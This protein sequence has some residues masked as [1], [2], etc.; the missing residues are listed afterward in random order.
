MPDH[1][2]VRRKTVWTILRWTRFQGATKAPHAF[3]AV[4]AMDYMGADCF[5]ERAP[6]V[7]PTRT[8]LSQL[9]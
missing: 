4:L 8:L 9:L 3:Q 1:F 6:V 2:T 7:V 5:A